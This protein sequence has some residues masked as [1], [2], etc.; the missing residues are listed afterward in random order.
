MIGNHLG[1]GRLLGPGHCDRSELF[2][3]SHYRGFTV[4]TDILSLLFDL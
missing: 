3:I 4:M 1:L 2:E